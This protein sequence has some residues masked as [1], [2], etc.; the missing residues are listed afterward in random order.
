MAEG[1][2]AI[3]LTPEQE[4]ALTEMAT[5]GYAHWKANAS[6]EVRAAGDAEMAK[7]TTD[8]QYGA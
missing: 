2:P 8:P 5:A 3:A 1:M 6:A 4:A 7:F